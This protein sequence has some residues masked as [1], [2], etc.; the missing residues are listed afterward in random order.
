VGMT[1]RF[2]RW[3]LK[4]AWRYHRRRGHPRAEERALRRLS[5]LLERRGAL[6]ALEGREDPESKR[7]LAALLQRLG[8]DR[9]AAHRYR[10]LRCHYLAGEAF[11]RLGDW[12]Q[13]ARSFHLSGSFPDAARC[14]ERWLESIDAAMRSEDQTGAILA[15]VALCYDRLGETR[16]AAELYREALEILDTHAARHEAAGRLQPARAAYLAIAH[17]GHS[18]GAYE[19]IACGLSGAIRV[20]KRDGGSEHRL[21]GYYDDFIHYSLRFGEFASAAELCVEAAELKSSQASA[22]NYLVRAGDSWLRNGDFLYVQLDRAELAS[23]SYHAAIECYLRAH[24]HDALV[25]C[26]ARLSVVAEPS[27]KEEFTRLSEALAQET[28]REDHPIQPGWRDQ[29]PEEWVGLDSGASREALE[30]AYFDGIRRHPPDTDVERFEALTRAFEVLSDD[31]KRVR[32]QA[33][34]GKQATPTGK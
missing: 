17:I 15:D 30:K 20:S 11:A 33:L 27:R 3:A 8:N 5:Q 23:A 18:K 16:R 34:L 31:R 13:A 12:Q 9:E 10:E 28:S 24:D 32:F 7:E 1:S 25:S 29:T 19:S 22:R 26:Y 6:A 4:F 14:W 21:L 2:R